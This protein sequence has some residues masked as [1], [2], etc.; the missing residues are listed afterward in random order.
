MN[1]FNPP[2]VHA[3]RHSGVMHKMPFLKVAALCNLCDSCQNHHKVEIL[4]YSVS[5]Q[6]SKW[7]R[8]FI[9][10]NFQKFSFFLL[11]RRLGFTCTT[12]ADKLRFL[13][14]DSRCLRAFNRGFPLFF[15]LF[16][17]Q[18]ARKS[19][20]IYEKYPFLVFFG[21]TDGNFT[22][23]Y[24]VTPSWQRTCLW[25]MTGV[26]IVSCRSADFN[27]FQM[28]YKYISVSS[29]DFGSLKFPWKK[30]QHSE[31]GWYAHDLRYMFVVTSGS[32]PWSLI[33]F[34]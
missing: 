31:S 28:T 32:P 8:D 15:W 30:V 22:E 14:S 4:N 33:N 25:Q 5:L 34:F 19:S 7:N 26:R 24:S 6:Y 9:T 20:D 17:L 1:I 16:L 2:A 3:G 27:L 13:L 10:I 29:E 23:K 12:A 11:L 18:N 21:A